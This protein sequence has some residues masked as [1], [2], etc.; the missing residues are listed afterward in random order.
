[1]SDP[2]SQPNTLHE[3]LLGLFPDSSV[4][5]IVTT[6]FDPHFETVIRRQWPDGSVEIYFAPALPRG[7]DFSGLVYLHGRLHKPGRLILTDKDFG[8]AYLTAGWARL[9][10]QELFAHYTVLFI[11]YSHQDVVMNYLA[12]GLPPT[13][14]PNRYALVDSRDN[15]SRWEYLGI[16]PVVYEWDKEHSRLQEFVSAWAKLSQ[17]EALEREV[18]IRTIV[19]R[20]PAALTKEEEDYLLYSLSNP[21]W[22]Q[23]FFRYA[24]AVGWLEW[25]DSKGLLNPLFD[26][27]SPGD[28]LVNLTDWFCRDPLGERGSRAV[29]IAALRRV[30]L[31]YAL[32]HTLEHRVWI[33]MQENKDRSKEQSQL[34][35]SWF[36]VLASQEPAGARWNIASY[37]LKELLVPQEK[38]IILQLL[39]V[40]TDP[41]MRAQEGFFPERPIRYE[42]SIKGDSHWLNDFRGRLR[43]NLPDLSESVLSLAV[44]NLEEAHNVL[45]LL[46]TASDRWD[47]LSFH[48]SRVEEAADRSLRTEPIL[49]LVDFAWMAIEHLAEAKTRNLTHFILSLSEHRSP[50][51]RRICISGVRVLPDLSCEEK[52]RLLIANNWLSL[53]PEAFRLLAECYPRLPSAARREFLDTAEEYYREDDR[54]SKERN[55]EA[56]EFAPYN[57]YNLL[58]WLL[59]ADPNCPCW[60]SAS[61]RSKPSTLSIKPA[62]TPIW[63]I[64]LTAL[65]A[66][67]R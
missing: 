63:I 1:L 59:Q 35:A 42:I 47:D 11:G 38:E 33:A 58:A 51:I 30:P 27:S 31:H 61:Q 62:S 50:L 32:W 14:Q 2:R 16:T 67:L 56:S 46:G 10:L 55:P 40:L 18:Q 41:H 44:Q 39:R 36:G 54:L 22:A 37:W 34:L 53:K 4:L 3:G 28:A 19:E 23:Y 43:E 20:D 13:V 52:V 57:N 9:F 29:R 64:G 60:P 17:Q 12:R 7:D 15:R 24:L 5:R 25:A 45:R 26:S 6:N 8:Q 48:R 66:S 65:G 21:A 49:T